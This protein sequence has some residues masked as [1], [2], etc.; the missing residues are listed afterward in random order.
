MSSRPAPLNDAQ[1]ELVTVAAVSVS[2]HLLILDT[3]PMEVIPK[4]LIVYW[5]GL[6]PRS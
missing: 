4:R 1:L 2:F 6:T 5:E 3:R